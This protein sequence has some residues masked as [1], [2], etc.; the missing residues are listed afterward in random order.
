MSSSFT[1]LFHI[2]FPVTTWFW[3]ILWAA[4]PQCGK[5]ESILK[6]IK[7]LWNVLIICQSSVLKNTSLPDSFYSSISVLLVYMCGTSILIFEDSPSNWQKFFAWP[8][9]G[10]TIHYFVTVSFSNRMPLILCLSR[11]SAYIIKKKTQNGTL[12]TTDA[13][14]T[15]TFWG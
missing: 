3:F 1:P 15:R 14:L 10:L 6:T 12:Q 9:F 4:Y 5:L 11:L 13:G 8:S 7:E 2:C